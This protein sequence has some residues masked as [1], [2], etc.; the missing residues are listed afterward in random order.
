M[1]FIHLR[2]IPDGQVKTQRNNKKAFKS[3]CYWNRTH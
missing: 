2:F 3:M 1:Q